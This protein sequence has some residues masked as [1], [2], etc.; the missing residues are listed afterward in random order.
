MASF[1]ARL[2]QACTEFGV[3]IPKP[4]DFEPRG[5]AR[6]FFQASVLPEYVEGSRGGEYP[7]MMLY[8]TGSQN[9]NEQKFQTFSGPVN[10]SIDYWIGTR[11][12]SAPVNAETLV[13]AVESA[14][15]ALFND[16][17]WEAAYSGDVAYNGDLAVVR[18]P[19]ELAG[20]H[21]R[22]AVAA[23]LVFDVAS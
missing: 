23:R 14:F 3:A 12:S 7:L 21:W 19:L 20:P 15:Y 2:E 16:P 6:N 5:K 9:R 1:N 11:D 18:R 17:D 10:V 8:G 13:D 22:Q 4:I